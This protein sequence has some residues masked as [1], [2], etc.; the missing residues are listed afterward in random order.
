[1]AQQP[2]TNKP[3]MPVGREAGL[4]S[5]T[6]IYHPT[7]EEHPETDRAK[8]SVPGAKRYVIGFLI[9]A[10]VIGAALFFLLR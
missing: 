6:T 8:S 9:A 4:H 3:A 5:E 2:L 1:M 7:G 10:A